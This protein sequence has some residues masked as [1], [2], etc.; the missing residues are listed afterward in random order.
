MAKN[1]KKNCKELLYLRLN[2]FGSAQIIVGMK[3]VALALVA[4][5]LDRGNFDRLE[6]EKGSTVKYIILG[7]DLGALVSALAVRKVDKVYSCKS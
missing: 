4:I 6:E 1:G 5:A 3:C 7:L 2:I